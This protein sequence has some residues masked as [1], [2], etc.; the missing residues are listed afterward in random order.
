MKQR[1]L[2]STIISNRPI[3]AFNN[4]QPIVPG[5]VYINSAAVQ[6][7]IKAGERAA[8]QEV[9]GVDP[10]TDD[11][12]KRDKSSELMLPYWDLV[13]D[14]TEGY[15]ALKRNGQKY[16]PKFHDETPDEYGDRLELS[17]FTNVYRD[18]VE[19]LASKP[20]EEQTTV[21]KPKKKDA[22]GK[23]TG[24]E[25]DLPEEIE[26]LAEDVD[27]SGNNLTSFAG[28]VFFNGINSA[29]HWVCVDYPKVDRSRVISKAQAKQENIRPFWSHVLGRNILEAQSQMING[30]E[31]L[32]YIRILEPGEPNHIRIYA[33]HGADPV[34]GKGAV[35]MGLFVEKVEGN[36]KTYVLIETAEITIGVIPMVPFATGRRDGRTFRFFPPM[37]DAADLQIQTYQ[38]ECGLKFVRTM[39]AYPMLTGNGVKPEKGADGK[40]VRL[41]V[42]PSKVLYAPTDGSGN[43]GSWAYISPDAEG[44]KFLKEDI[45]ETQEQLRELGRQPLTAQSNNLTVITTAYAAG[46][47]KTA[48]GAWAYLL[49]DCLENCMLIS[50]LWL[51]ITDAKYE[52]EIAVFTD[53]DDY[54][55][56]QTADLDALAKARESR[57]LS[58]SNF[59]RELK[60]R[61][62]LRADF[63]IDEN[64]AELLEETPSEDELLNDGATPP[65]PGAKP[66]PKKPQPPKKVTP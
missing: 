52:P 55:T 28:T 48:V 59:L 46:K 5:S 3:A 33:R 17:E 11:L 27:G 41:R 43:V 26:A 36:A 62:T 4:M 22:N 12:G 49:Q 23:S 1:L 63:D 16:L 60:R 7:M 18:S 50:C 58:H 56:D 45:K 44:L 51:G 47:A 25:M 21:V 54:A 9:L 19:T 57:D 13:D 10:V 40:P 30:K 8:N 64:D 61:S 32:V 14:I 35:T 6:A 34:T 24:E 53:F 2:A 20:F 66:I 31:T 65:K 37:R 15:E 42:G 38:K 39:V 29:I